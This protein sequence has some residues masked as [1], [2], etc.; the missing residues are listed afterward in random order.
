[1]LLLLLDIVPVCKKPVVEWFSGAKH[2]EECLVR[3]ER[4]ALGK[5]NNTL[6]HS[7]SVGMKRK[8]MHYGDCTSHPCT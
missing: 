7:S 6:I 8:Q 2:I 1:M 3:E 5:I 4:E